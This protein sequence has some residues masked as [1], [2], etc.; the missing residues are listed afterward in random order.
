[1]KR[2]NNHLMRR[3][4]TRRSGISSIRF[5]KWQ[6]VLNHHLFVSPPAT[7]PFL[8]VGWWCTKGGHL[9]SGVNRASCLGLR[10]WEFTWCVLKNTPFLYYKSPPFVLQ[11]PPL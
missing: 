2:Y 5:H 11:N 10:Q 8:G 7:C 3:S 4:E 6:P 1:M 9:Q